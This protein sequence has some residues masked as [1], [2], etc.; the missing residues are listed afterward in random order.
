MLTGLKSYIV[1]FIDLLG[2]S[3]MVAHD[4]ATPNGEQKFIEALYECHVETKGLK[5]EHPDLQLIQFSD[6]VVLAFPYSID[7]YKLLVRV[8]SDYQ[9]SLLGKGILCRGGVSYGKHFFTEGFLFSNGMIE[10]Y[11]LE[12]SVA[13]VPRVVISSELMDLVGPAINTSE[14]GMPI[15]RENDG[16]YF[17]DYLAGREMNEASN[18][19]SKVVP[20]DLNTSP[21]IR[22]KQ[23]WMLDYYNYSFPGESNV[24][25]P[26]F[27]R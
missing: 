27:S 25:V 21:S 26:K 14:I 16:I 17:I 12:S 6:S 10:A 2:F 20:S 18:N 8:I 15:I 19:I 11:R 4:C 3:S 24:V 1:A 13:V 5:S 9:Y 22:N 7:N 23:I